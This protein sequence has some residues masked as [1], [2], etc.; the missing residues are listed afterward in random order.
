MESRIIEI[1]KST[2]RW[3]KFLENPEQKQVNRSNHR[4]DHTVNSC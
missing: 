4:K 3:D 1:K 2:K